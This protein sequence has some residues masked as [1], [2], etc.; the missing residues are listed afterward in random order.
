MIILKLTGLDFLGKKEKKSLS[1]NKRVYTLEGLRKI[2][3]ILSAYFEGGV[4]LHLGK[5]RGKGVSQSSGK[6]EL[7]NIER[8]TP[9]SE[10]GKY[11]PGGLKIREVERKGERREPLLTRGYR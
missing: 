7:E 9:T 6:T 4:C 8:V 10:E 5:R 1:T 2:F 11:S 3:Y